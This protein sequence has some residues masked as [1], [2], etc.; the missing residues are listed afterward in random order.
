MAR[1]RVGMSVTAW[2]VAGLW[3]AGVA[4]A[5]T[6]AAGTEPPG[7][8]EPSVPPVRLELEPAQ[9]EALKLTMREHLAALEAIV[10]ALGRQDY[11]AAADVAHLK[12][13][14]PKHH[15]AMQRERGAQLPK[16]YQDL[17]LAHHQA[18]EALA[19]AIATKE[20]PPIL[21][22]LARTIQSCTACHRA[23]RL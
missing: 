17:A 4:P 12:L 11:R 1:Q 19:E 10:S 7:A 20:M 6:N 21:R 14:F 18:A 16:Q 22:Q 23:Y 3:A 8:V 2:L 13:G 9:R 15:E 5:G